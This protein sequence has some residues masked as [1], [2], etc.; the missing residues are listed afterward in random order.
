MSTDEKKKPYTT[1]Y[2]SRVFCLQVLSDELLVSGHQ[3]GDIVVWKFHATKLST[4]FHTKQILK[5]HTDSVISLAVAMN[6]SGFS[7]SLFKRVVAIQVEKTLPF[8]CIW[9]TSP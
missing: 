3:N 4:S 9:F 5:G 7:F 1:K 2:E 8:L 6:P